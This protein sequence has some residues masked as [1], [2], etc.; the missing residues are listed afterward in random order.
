MKMNAELRHKQDIMQAQ[1]KST[2][3]R[4]ADMEADLK[5][6]N[7]EIENLQAQLDR[8]NSNGPVRMPLKND[9]SYIEFIYVPFI[10]YPM[11]YDSL[12]L[13]FIKLCGF[14]PLKF[15]DISTLIYGIKIN[16]KTLQTNSKLVLP[17]Q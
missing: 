7:K 2:V 14:A 4:K 1:L 8:T 3:E 10:S 9:R 17:I 11:L 5:E 15:R 13:M 12:L 6:K 16:S